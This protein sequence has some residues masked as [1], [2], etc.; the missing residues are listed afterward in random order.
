MSCMG[1]E[2]IRADR[3]PLSYLEL[4]CLA[5]SHGGAAHP[6]LV[7][8]SVSLLNV[9]KNADRPRD[10]RDFKRRIMTA[11][12][13]CATETRAWLEANCP[14]EMREPIRSEADLCW[15]GRNWTFQSDAQRDWLHAMAN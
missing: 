5:P 1:R 13:A 12:A 15:G 7:Q 3:F 2:R 14:Q 9:T 11:P 8:S 10:I 4:K 6:Q